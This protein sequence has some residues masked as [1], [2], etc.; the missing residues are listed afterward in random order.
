[1]N[2]LSISSRKQKKKKKKKLNLLDDPNLDS[3]T[4]ILV[5][6]YIFLVTLPELYERMPKKCLKNPKKMIKWLRKELKNGNT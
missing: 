6:F 2:H 1:M 3:D 5:L 4:K